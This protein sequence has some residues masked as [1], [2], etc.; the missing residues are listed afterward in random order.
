[1]HGSDS[2]L[3]IQ[4]MAQNSASAHLTTRRLAH[5]AVK[6][7]FVLQHFMGTLPLR[8]C[9]KSSRS[10][11]LLLRNSPYT[12][13]ATKMA[14]SQPTLPRFVP[15]VYRQ[16]IPMWYLSTPRTPP[17]PTSLNPFPPTIQTK[18]QL[19][20]ALWV[21]HRVLLHHSRKKRRPRLYNDTILRHPKSKDAAHQKEDAACAETFYPA[22]VIATC[23]TL[24]AAL[25]H[26][27]RRCSGHCTRSCIMCA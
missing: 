27:P 19:Y 18:R 13:R 11:Q 21:I 24:R 16:R 6:V 25:M 3:N 23:A 20:H 15:L 2:S 17:K 7:D 4:Q 9:L 14:I 5:Q 8:P 10:I 22:W 1:M 26:D 12:H